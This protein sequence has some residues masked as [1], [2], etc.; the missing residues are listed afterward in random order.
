MKDTQDA[1]GFCAGVFV[2]VITPWACV[3]N[4]GGDPFAMYEW[5]AGVAGLFIWA[6]LAIPTPVRRDNE[7]ER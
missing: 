1:L 7:T 3:A 4:E 6:S 5:A 2:C